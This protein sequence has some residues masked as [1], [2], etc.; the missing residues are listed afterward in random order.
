MICRE[1]EEFVIMRTV[2]RS[3]ANIGARLVGRQRLYRLGRWAYMRARNDVPNSVGQNG[4][5]RVQ[6]G[7][8]AA[9]MDSGKRI[10]VLDI[11]AN[12]GDWLRP[13]VRQA[14]RLGCI[15]Q[16]DVH[17]FEPAPTTHER[18]VG[19]VTTHLRHASIRTNCMAVS[20]T[21]SGATLY[22]TGDG[23]G[24]NSL[25]QESLDSGTQSVSVPTT[26]IDRYLSDMSIEMAHLIKSD[27][28]GHDM[29]VLRGAREMLRQ[30]RI[31]VFQFEYNHR[32]IHSRNFLKDA[33]A[34]IAGLPYSVGKVTPRLIEYYEEWHPEL[35]RFIEGNYVIV[36][37]RARNWFE[38]CAIQFDVSNTMVCDENPIA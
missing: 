13:L 12:V 1:G 23:A 2:V 19:G 35:E 5:E 32:W 24:T 36:H 15:G 20:S 3:L 29:E 7:V 37:Q 16:M 34:L 6:A 22:V 27:T 10:V 4:E 31:C 28:E 11:G 33:F 17:A 9:C 21:Q 38:N 30:E 14:E 18:L 26:T 8:L 25:H